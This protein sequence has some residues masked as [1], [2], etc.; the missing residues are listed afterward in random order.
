MMQATKYQEILRSV[1]GRALLTLDECFAPAKTA[2]GE[3]L[4]YRITARQVDQVHAALDVI[5][6]ALINLDLEPNM[7]AI[8]ARARQGAARHKPASAAA[9]TL[10]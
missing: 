2:N 4:P 3:P 1:G 10:F 9:R 7:T 5:R 8:Q 6:A